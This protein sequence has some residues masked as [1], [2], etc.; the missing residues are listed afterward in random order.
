[1]LLPF[2][3]FEEMETR[4]RDVKKH[5]FQVLCEKLC[6]SFGSDLLSSCDT[7]VVS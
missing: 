1:M 4:R 2:T 3:V 6:Q 7:P 5:H